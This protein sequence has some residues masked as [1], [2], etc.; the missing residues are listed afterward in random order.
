ML[1]EDT[2]GD[3]GREADG[4][5][6]GEVTVERLLLVRICRPFLTARTNSFICDVKS[7]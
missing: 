2:G 6:A 5:E 7:I 4:V 3:V 1:V